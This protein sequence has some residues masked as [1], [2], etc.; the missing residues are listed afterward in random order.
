MKITGVRSDQRMPEALVELFG[1]ENRSI[2]RP[3]LCVEDCLR[4]SCHENGENQQVKSDKPAAQV[5]MIAKRAVGV[6]WR[7]A[8][9]N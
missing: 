3:E 4:S 1:K 2:F 9:A 7:R 5:S 6:V 8:G